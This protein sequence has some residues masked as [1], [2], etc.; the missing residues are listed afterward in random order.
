MSGLC[1]AAQRSLGQ[2]VPLDT[3]NKKTG[4]MAFFLGVRR[5]HHARTK[6]VTR[7]FKIPDG[8]HCP[9]VPAAPAWASPVSHYHGTPHQ[10]SFTMWVEPSQVASCAAA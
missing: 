2:P 3:W 10:A 7:H 5:G 4:R 1:V 8:L 9:K 6:E